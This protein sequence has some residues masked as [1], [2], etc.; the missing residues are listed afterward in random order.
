MMTGD[1]LVGPF[2]GAT[3]IAIAE[4]TFTHELNLTAPPRLAIGL[5]GLYSWPEA[6]PSF[7]GSEPAERRKVTGSTITASAS[8]H[9][10]TRLS[11]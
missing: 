10:S 5:A 7:R 6:A 4:D 2:C 8:P 9:P 11:E 1:P 3:V